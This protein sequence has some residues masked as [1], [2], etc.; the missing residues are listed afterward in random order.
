MEASCGESCWACVAIHAW[1]GHREVKN[2]RLGKLR[3]GDRDEE[4]RVEKIVET[5]R[6]LIRKE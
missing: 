5:K 3:Q 4:I 6:G 2:G 1:V